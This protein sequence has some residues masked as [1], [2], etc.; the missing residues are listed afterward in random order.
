[1][2]SY[3]FG[4]ADGGMVKSKYQAVNLSN[5]FVSAGLGIALETKLGLL[6]VSYALGK[7]DDV[8][9]N[10]RGASKIHFGYVNYF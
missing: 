3:F 2:N 6:N 4:F 10:L 9:F 1:L 7:R 5:N 8:K